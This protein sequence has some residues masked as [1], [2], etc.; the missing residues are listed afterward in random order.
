MLLVKCLTHGWIEIVN[1]KR[2]LKQ[3]VGDRPFEGRPENISFQRERIR[4]YCFSSWLSKGRDV[5]Y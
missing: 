4:I 3:P 5:S 2:I 1:K